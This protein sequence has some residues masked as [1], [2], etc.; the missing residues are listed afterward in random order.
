MKW[1][2]KD[3]TEIEVKQDEH[4]VSRSQ[5]LGGDMTDVSTVPQPLYHLQRRHLAA[6]ALLQQRR[7]HH[8]LLRHH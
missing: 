6:A 4:S 8:P 5:T 7:E 2:F 1:T 3:G